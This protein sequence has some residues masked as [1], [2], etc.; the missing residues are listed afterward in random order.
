MKNMIISA[1]KACLIGASMLVPG[2]SGG[3]MAMILG[4]YD[5]LISSVSS[6]FKNV[7]D[8]LVFLGVFCGGALIG[9][10]LFARPILALIQRFPMPMLYFFMGT[11]LGSIPMIFKK[12]K[13]NKLSLD[14]LIYPLLGFILV[15][16]LA[17]LPTGLI[18]TGDNY[19]LTAMMLVV[20]GVVAA[21]ALVLPG[22]SVSYM[23]LLLGMYDTILSAV[24]TLDFPFLVPLGIGLVLGIVA[25][26][27]ILENCMTKAPKPTYLIILGFLFGSVY[28]IFPGIPEGMTLLISLILLCVSS[29]LIYKISNME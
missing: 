18:Q 25:T 13:V 17:K 14:V 9:M 19:I 29:F 7:K 22:I 10:I 24:S 28:E 26:T 20:A 21:V 23:F 16:L 4:I 11:V 5:R 15:M 6:F 1:L 2:V 12:A 8:N 27:R 3:S